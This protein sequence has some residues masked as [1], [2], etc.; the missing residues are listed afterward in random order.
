MTGKGRSFER[1]AVIGAGN[2]GSGIA[3]KMAAEGFDVVLIDVDASQVER[4]LAAIDRTLAEAVE[5]KILR[6]EQVAAIRGRLVGTTDWSRLADVDLVVEAVFE[7]LAVKRQVF[8]RLDAACPPQAILGTN[9]SSLSVTE[10]A[11]ATRRPERVV[12]LHYFYHPAKNRLVEVVPGARTDPAVLAAAWT[13]QELLGKTPIASADAPGFVVNRY[14]V[15]WLNEAVRLVEE[16]AATIPTIEEACRRTFGVGLGPFELMNVTGVPIALHAATTLGCALGPFYAPAARLAQQVA[17]ARPWDLAGAVDDGA[18][19]AVSQRMLAVAFYVASALVEER[20][21]TVEDCDIG[22]RVGLRWPHGPF[23]LMNRFGVEAGAELVDRLARRWELSVPRILAMH[24]ANR[25][26]FSFRLVT[27]SV[28]DGI[29]TLRIN[30][31]DAM[32]ALDEELVKQLH[33]AFREAMFQ[34]QIRAIVLAGAGKA[35]VAGADIRF[36]VR[37][38]E[39][40]DFERILRFTRAGHELL[41]EIDASP[42]PVVARL[43]GLALGGGVELALACDRIV[44]SPKAGL[45]FP[46]TGIG[47]YPGLGGTQRLPRRVGS[48]LA[49]WLVYTGQMLAAEDARAIGLVDDV[50]PYERLDAAIREWI[51]GGAS[52]AARPA[53]GERHRALEALFGS[54]SVDTLRQ[55]RAA[56]EEALV[57]AVKQVGYKAPLALY[58]AERLIDAAAERELAAGLE[59]ELEQLVEIF[60][61]ADAY[62]GLSS[63]GRKKPA[64]HGR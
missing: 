43:H 32:N 21:G 20:V 37:H 61:T 62:E 23:E 64:F 8:E 26:P 31:P 22:A 30:R 25:E 46:E 57:R 44:A 5:R 34:P 49:K 24:A 41:N 54:V 60:R 42:K 2:M 13:L 9:T 10:L 4:G 48:G 51:D 39:G 7:D 59:L 52:P 11:D 50:V 47:I 16:G 58:A 15:P 36:F 1:L 6:A 45:A 35:F 29:A 40:G 53:L 17:S 55:G 18:L 14:F 33:E 38:I 28:E 19:E 56:G 63:L 3:Q 12:G 27:T